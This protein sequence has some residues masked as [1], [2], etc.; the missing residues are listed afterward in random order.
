MMP[1]TAVS[2]Q[3]PSSPSFVFMFLLR[4]EHRSGNPDAWEMTSHT[5]AMMAA[6]GVY[7]QIGGGFH[8]YAVDPQWRVPHFEKMLYDQAQLV[9]TCLD[10]FQISGDDGCVATARGT[11]DYVLRDMTDREGGFSFCRRCG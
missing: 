4:Y 1:R 8:R 2:A 9:Q 6:G 10:V 11:L 3:A 5:L 7:D